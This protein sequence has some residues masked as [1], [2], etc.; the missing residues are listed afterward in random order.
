MKSLGTLTRLPW[1][2]NTSGDFAAFCLIEH[3]TGFQS[4]K[5]YCQVSL[6]LLI[7]APSPLF[8]DF[9]TSTSGGS[10]MRK[11][12]M[13]TLTTLFVV[14]SLVSGCECTFCPSD[15]PAFFLSVSVAP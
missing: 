2:L 9:S 14:W 15:D 1:P 6:I 4:D 10:G 11:T 3:F 5:V 12:K 13:M 8:A 7:P